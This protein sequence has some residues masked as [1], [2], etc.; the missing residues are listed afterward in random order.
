MGIFPETDI[1]PRQARMV[2]NCDECESSDFMRDVKSQ[3]N[4]GFVV[5]AQ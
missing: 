1:D 4:G 2:S 3:T 5:I